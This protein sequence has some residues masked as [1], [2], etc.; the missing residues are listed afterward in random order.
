MRGAIRDRPP[1]LEHVIV[2]GDKVPDGCIAWADLEARGTLEFPP[3][4][5]SPDEPHVLAYTSGTTA[6]PKGVVHSH[7]TLL[8]ECRA[9][10]DSS[11]R[12]PSDVFPCPTPD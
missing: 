6:D 7:N 9:L 5:I 3:P 1:W 8:A 12:R 10:V 11:G 2:V 4:E